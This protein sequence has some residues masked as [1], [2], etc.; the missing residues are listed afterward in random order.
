MTTEIRNQQSIFPDMPREK[1]VLD[2]DGNFTALWDL[3]LSALFQA[4]QD[5]FKNEGIR[6]P[7]LSAANMTT[8]QALY[9]SYVGGTYNALTLAQ[10]DIS[11]QTVYDST[12]YTTNQFVI[13][14][15]GSGNVTM[16]QWVPL[17]VM[18]TTTG[19]PNLILAGVANWL[20]YDTAGN[21]LYI[22][23]L[24]GAAGVATWIAV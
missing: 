22:C 9:A 21:V 11:G 3:G 6:I 10:P 15:D 7:P 19:T 12:T 5:N 8:I 17:S 4:L 13:A 1:P 2:K 14:Q 16:A 18:L 20:C 24:S 23:T